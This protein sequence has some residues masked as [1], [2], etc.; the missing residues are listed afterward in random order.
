MLRLA[1]PSGLA[2][3]IGALPHLDAVAAARFVLDEMEMPAI[4]MLPRRSPAEASIALALVGMR[5]IT[6]GQ[7]GSISVDVHALDASAPVITDLAADPFVGFRT[8]LAE[9]VAWQR[10]R[11]RTIR[12]LK[13]QFVGPVT[14][15]LTLIRAG[16]DEG[17]AFDVAVHAVR[18]RVEFLIDAVATVLP[19][20]E[21]VVM[22]EEP[23]L[24]DVLQPGFPL[25]LD[26]ALDLVSGA[27]AMVE[28][29]ATSGLH[30]CGLADVPMQLAAGPAVLSLPVRH[31]VLSSAGYLDRYLQGGGYIA[32]GVVATT[33][34]LSASADRPL[35][36]LMALWG[37]LAEQGVDTGR[38]HRQALITPEC[39]LAA[40][41]PAVAHRVHRL[42]AEVAQRVRAG[43]PR[44]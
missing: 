5:G 22:I 8:F 21:Q 2:T 37:Q 25:A 4:P 35:R 24:R 23:A 33:G 1:L 29:R 20:V 44:T 26:A 42:V 19:E 41:S 40:H 7:Y 14:L 18:A 36:Q 27:M 28:R 6:I 30:V 12:Y 15:G 13:W 39:G 16:V 10:E 9:S 34:P 31:E 43:A 11:D 38:L 17:V 32:W 3:G